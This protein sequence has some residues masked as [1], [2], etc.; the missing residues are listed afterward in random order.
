MIIPSWNAR[1]ML[2]RCLRSLAPGVDADDLQAVQVL[3]VDDASSDG[4]AEAAA[5]SGPWV[6]V[7]AHD[8]NRGFAATCNTGAAAASGRWLLFLNADAFVTRAQ[9]H[10]LRGVAEE[11]DAAALGPRLVFGDGSAQDSGGSFPRPASIALTKLGRLLGREY[12]GASHRSHVFG[13][14]PVDW[15]G[16]ACLLVDADVFRAVEGFDDNL[17]YFEDVDLCR[18]IGLSGG[19]V[20]LTDR[21]EVTHIGGASFS[22]IAA[23][24][25]RRYRDS[26]RR[27]AEKHW[28]RPERVLLAAGESLQ[29]WLGLVERMVQAFRPPTWS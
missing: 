11:L 24:V 17:T 29:G 4:S 8:V 10:E 27:L 26:R 19:A 13:T 14:S 7:I 6:S 16:G 20:Y 12:A 18:R 21:V 3:V 23:Q 5:G 9:V 15:V 28:S 2:Q 1:G 25:P 22:L